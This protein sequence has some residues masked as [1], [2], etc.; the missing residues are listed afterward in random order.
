[1]SPSVDDD[2][3]VVMAAIASGANASRASVQEHLTI[4]TKDSDGTDGGGGD[5]ASVEGEK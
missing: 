3:V 4:A 1:M 5:G 2:D